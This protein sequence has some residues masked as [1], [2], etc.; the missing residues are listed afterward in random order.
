[1]I[2]FNEYFRKTPFIR[3]L[4]PLI[5][6][7]IVSLNILP[8]RIP[9]LK[10]LIFAALLVFTL[11]IVL[12]RTSKRI[13]GLTFGLAINLVFVLL[14][15]I[16]IQ[17]KIK[18][19][20]DS[21]ILFNSTAIVAEVID[22]PVEKAKTFRILLQTSGIKENQSWSQK[23]F[24]V[25]AYVQKSAA[26]EELI[27]GDKLLI[28]AKIRKFQTAG[29]PAEFD[30]PGYMS[31]RNIFGNIYVKDNQW[32]KTGDNLGPTLR[33]IPAALRNTAFQFLQQSLEN[34][35]VLAVTSALLLGER[36]YIDEEIKD[37]FA[38][39][40]VI[41]TMAVSGL[42]VGIIYLILLNLLSF[43]DRIKFGKKI[44]VFI[45]ILALW[46]YALITGMS[47]SV[48]RA[49]TMFSFV[50]IGQGLKRPTSIYN[51]LAVSAFLLLCINP[52]F[53]RDIGFQLSFSAVFGIVFFYPGIYPILQSR[54]WLLD[55]AWMLIVVSFSAQLATF[56]L[57]AYYFHQFPNYFLLT[58]LLAIP[59]VT[60][61]IYLGL[62]LLIFSFSG[63]I[64]HLLSFLVSQFVKGLMLVVDSVNSLPF[65]VTKPIFLD[66]VGSFLLYL[67]LLLGILF[68]LLKKVKYLNYGLAVVALFIGWT[69]LLNLRANNQK[70]LS[71]F[72]INGI[73]AIQFVDGKMA[74]LYSSAESDQMKQNVGKALD[75]YWH[76]LRLKKVQW[77][78][79]N[80]FNVSNFKSNALYVNKGFF[81]FYDLKG[82]L[83]DLESP[84]KERYGTLAKTDILIVSGANW[85]PTAKFNKSYQPDVLIVDSSVPWYYS[86]QITSYCEQIDMD[87]FPVSSRGAFT[88]EVE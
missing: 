17:L 58:N 71:V 75:G 13:L 63:F 31:D 38:N 25:L 14:G 34:S 19:E 27:P 66:S 64:S 53:I 15:V 59:L 37:S 76:Q 79:I 78:S 49:V 43:F 51:S 1:M 62:S 83:Y 52:Y 60:L 9:D 50:A 73:S 72:N 24:K 46:I 16:L 21:A 18:K 44:K 10:W 28:H 80:D 47:P 26:V 2:D 74:Y 68:F 48:L 30:Y 29:N 56:P 4:I 40:G 22:L 65:S 61:I 86:N 12:Y 32:K 35:D 88:H 39:A 57:V 3:F 81:Q 7:I 41:H 55:K 87:C 23:K 84:I 45:I 69:L 33:V 36:D 11:I 77:N 82:F 6:G 54:F 70:S 5:I 42:H 67:I 20:N 85:L 8:D